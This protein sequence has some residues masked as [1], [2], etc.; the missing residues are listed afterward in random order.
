MVPTLTSSALLHVII[1]E[2]RSRISA[3]KERI[4]TNHHLLF[5][6][7]TKSEPLKVNICTSDIY[8]R[9][10]GEQKLKFD[11]KKKISNF[12]F[13]LLRS[14]GNKQLLENYKERVLNLEVY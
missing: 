6:I 13:H 8:D 5:I 11:E 3:L 10:M 1:G 12:L 2:K 4:F 14:F 9:I 7:K